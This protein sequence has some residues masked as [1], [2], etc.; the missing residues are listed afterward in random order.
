VRRRSVR[1]H[2]RDTFPSISI[3]GAGACRR[4]GRPA[5]WYDRD[6]GACPVWGSSRR[7]ALRHGQGPLSRCPRPLSGTDLK[8]PGRP[9]GPARWFPT[10][11]STPVFRSLAPRSSRFTPRPPSSLGSGKPPTSSV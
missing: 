8:W 11:S 9:S 5:G 6:R 3:N 10:I 7:R 2:P 4:Y 1:L